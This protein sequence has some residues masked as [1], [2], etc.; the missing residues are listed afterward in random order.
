M[1]KWMAVVAL[2]AMLAVSGCKTDNDSAT[3]ND[4]PKK[5]S[6]GA[7]CESCATKTCD[8]NAKTAK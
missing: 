7:D 5:M 2:G 3:I 4:E 6:A 8:A 1:T